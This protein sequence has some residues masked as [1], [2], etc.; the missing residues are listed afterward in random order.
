MPTYPPVELDAVFDPIKKPLVLLYTKIIQ[1]NIIVHYEDRRCYLINSDGQ[2]IT[3]YQSRLSNLP[4][5]Y[6]FLKAFLSN[7]KPRFIVHIEPTKTYFEDNGVRYLYCFHEAPNIIY[8]RQE[9]LEE[10]VVTVQADLVFASIEEVIILIKFPS[11]V[12]YLL[13]ANF[14]LLETI[15]NREF[16]GRKQQHCKFNASQYCYEYFSIGE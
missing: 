8:V 3:F 11:N 5:Q 1:Q 4:K 14:N 10:P 16:L 12:V 2:E 9:Y 13:I 15:P 7:C 6:T